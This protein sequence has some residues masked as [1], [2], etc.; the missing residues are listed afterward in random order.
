MDLFENTRNGL[1]FLRV[2]DDNIKL[3]DVPLEIKNQLQPLMNT[4]FKN[5][6]VIPHFVF[7][8]WEK[9][10][11]LSFTEIVDGQQG[12]TH[13]LQEVEGKQCL[14]LSTSTDL[15]K[16]KKVPL[17]CIRLLMGH[18]HFYMKEMV[19]H[20]SKINH[21]LVTIKMVFLMTLMIM[22]EHE[23]KGV[24][25]F[26]WMASAKCVE[27]ENFDPIQCKMSHDDSNVY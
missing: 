17:F 14:F 19:L 5:K 18:N 4:L 2:N 15:D 26:P 21:R 20:L 27:W 7:G 22:W 1:T 8:N 6:T 23:F 11:G 16:V 13:F 3:Y 12:D 25:F 9:P 10:L 24:F